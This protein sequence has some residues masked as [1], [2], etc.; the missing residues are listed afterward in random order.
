M[1]Y[2]TV[3][4]LSKDIRSLLHCAQGV[5][6]T[7]K[8]NG[9]WRFFWH[10]YTFLLAFVHIT[11][12]LNIDFIHIN[13]FR[14][15]RLAGVGAPGP[16]SD[17]FFAIQRS[18]PGADGCPFRIFLYLCVYKHTLINFILIYVHIHGCDLLVSNITCTRELH[19]ILE[20]IVSLFNTI[21]PKP[22]L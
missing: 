5:K 16:C 3:E 21:Y 11:S 6:S 20:Q 1:I 7:H 4:S 2:F 10:S 22:K 19:Q 15:N 8:L 9:S 17:H 14:I 18:I 12:S 13:I